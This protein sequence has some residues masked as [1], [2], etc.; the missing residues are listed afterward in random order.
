MQTLN[1]PKLNIEKR[2]LDLLAIPVEQ[3]TLAVIEEA[4][5]YLRSTLDESIGNATAKLGVNAIDLAGTGGSGIQ[6]FNTSTTVSFV[7]AAHGVKVVK[8]GNRSI[9]GN[10]GSIDFLTAIGFETDMNI[11][12]LAGA[13]NQMDLVFLNAATCY[14]QIGLIREQRKQLGRP[15]IFN[16]IGPLLN[17][18]SPEFRLM[19]VSDNRVREILNQFLVEE[20]TINRAITMTSPD[21]LDELAPLGPNDVSM[22]DSAQLST[23]EMNDARKCFSSLSQS[24]SKVPDRSVTSSAK[25]NAKLFDEIITGSDTTSDAFASVVVNAGA[26]F[27]AAKAVTSLEDGCMLAQKLIANRSVQKKYEQLRSAQ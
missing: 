13:L 18:T 22:I 8:F 14:P 3:F 5:Q 12:H 9:T 23:I 6:K 25:Q 16:F 2:L 4:V 26:A 11:E 15:S 10:S 7:L 20:K 27:L 1:A 21:G 24:V 17:P 19:G